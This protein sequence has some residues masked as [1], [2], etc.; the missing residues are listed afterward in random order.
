MRAI[1]LKPFL[2]L[3]AVGLAFPPN[4]SAQCQVC[5]LVV[6]AGVGLSRWLGIDDSI[7][8]AW[9]GG[10]MVSLIL[11]TLAWME[12]KRLR[13]TADWV[14]AAAVF[15]LSLLGP[16]YL[17]GVIGQCANTLWGF[18]KLLLGIAVGSVLFF[19]GAWWYQRIKSHREHAYF[20]F[21]KVVMP[22]APLIV[23]SFIF[24]YLVK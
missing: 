1:R 8:G 11:G 2:G 7:S 22:V 12:R 18:D 13:F 5:T 14:L 4:A 6:G 16:L 23:V 3:L 17:T 24:Y 15:Y 19:L 10:L 20:P 21:Q 9:V